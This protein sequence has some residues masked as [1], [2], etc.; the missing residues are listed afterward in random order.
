MINY[1]DKYGGCTGD[2]VSG[3]D[4]SDGDDID[5]T[6]SDDGSSSCDTI[7]E[8][9]NDLDLVEGERGK[10]FVGSESFF[11]DLIERCMRASSCPQM[12]CVLF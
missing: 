4:T 6:D 12:V 5:E 10:F 11:F 3:Q 2:Y 8:R 7:I 1:C 9:L